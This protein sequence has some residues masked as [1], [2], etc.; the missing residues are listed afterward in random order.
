[1]SDVDILLLPSRGKNFCA[2]WSTLTIQPVAAI[3]RT[4]ISKKCRPLIILLQGTSAMFGFH[5]VP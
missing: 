3:E 4:S 1:M 2:C 5:S